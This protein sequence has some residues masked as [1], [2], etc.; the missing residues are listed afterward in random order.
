M[1]ITKKQIEANLT[2]VNSAETAIKAFETWRA[3]SMQERAEFIKKAGG[4]KSFT[5]D[6]PNPE[7]GKCKSVSYYVS[8]GVYLSMAKSS[9]TLKLKSGLSPSVSYMMDSAPDKDGYYAKE[10]GKKWKP[11]RVYQKFGK[12]EAV[13]ELWLKSGNEYDLA[14]NESLKLHL[15]AAF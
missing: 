9:K 3:M 1:A 7:K 8:G 4:E 12:Y 2:G 13:R 10:N 15:E 6:M 11:S 5:L 14:Q